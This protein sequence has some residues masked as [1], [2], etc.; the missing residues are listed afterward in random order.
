MDTA[1]HQEALAPVEREPLLDDVAGGFGHELM[2]C[3]ALLCDA[4]AHGRAAAAQ[5]RRIDKL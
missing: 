1:R 5:L 2:M 3:C 4:K